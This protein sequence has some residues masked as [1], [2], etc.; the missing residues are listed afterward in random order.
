M[1]ATSLLLTAFTL[2]FAATAATIS[3]DL[4]N[5]IALEK[6]AR[7]IIALSPHTAELLI[8]AGGAPYLVAAP[9]QTAGLPP[10][11]QQVNTLGGIDRERIMQLKPDLVLAWAS[12]N[13]ASDLAWLEKTGIPVFRSEPRSMQHIADSIS[14]IGQLVGQPVQGRKAAA[15]FLQRL[16]GACP[17]LGREEAYVSIWDQPAMTVGGRHWLNDALTHAGL[18]NTFETQK[19]GVFAVEREARM[20]REGLAQVFPRAPSATLSEGQLAVA[21]LSRP[22]PALAQAIEKLCR[23]RQLSSE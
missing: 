11:A 22:G 12:G 17:G 2:S 21:G 10:H 16:Q 1:K 15:N 6:P 7:R 4:G 23:S 13:R 8:A 5:N 20:T 9:A 3:D 19:S 14:A 18:V